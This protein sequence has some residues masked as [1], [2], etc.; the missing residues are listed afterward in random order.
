[1]KLRA[2][3]LASDALAPAAWSGSSKDKDAG[4]K[5]SGDAGSASAA[6][7]AGAGP[8]VEAAPFQKVGKAC[9][10]FLAVRCCAR[11]VSKLGHPL[12]PLFLSSHPPMEKAQQLVGQEH[13]RFLDRWAWDRR[14]DDMV[15]S[16]WVWFFWGRYAYILGWFTVVYGEVPF[17]VV[18]VVVAV[19]P[20]DRAAETLCERVKNSCWGS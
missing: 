17:V 12:S 15:T 7:A 16:V 9:C 2:A 5:Q 13:I 11:C 3:V 10:L 14:S 18:V 19:V 20:D 6:A 1:M 8:T 4:G